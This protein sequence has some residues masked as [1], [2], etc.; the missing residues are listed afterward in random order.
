MEAPEESSGSVKFFIKHQGDIARVDVYSDDF[1]TSKTYL[2]LSGSTECNLQ[3]SKDIFI[4]NCAY[5]LSAS[6]RCLCVVSIPVPPHS[7]ALSPSPPPQCDELQ[8][9]HARHP[10]RV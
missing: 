5:V 1:S 10:I 6:P 2:T 8:D 4:S 3:G 7:F 9:N